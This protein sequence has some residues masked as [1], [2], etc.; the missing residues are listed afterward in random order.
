M[1]EVQ[2]N[3]LV[4]HILVQKLQDIEAFLASELDL[5][6]FD[7]DLNNLS[8]M[9]EAM[10]AKF[11]VYFCWCTIDQEP[12]KRPKFCQ[13]GWLTSLS[14]NTHA[15]SSTSKMDE[16]YAAENKKKTATDQIC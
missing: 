10:L 1:I 14:T 6:S 15:G 11:K 2:T 16:C 7:I 5:T 4:G 13:V 12:E 3:N 9:W 8:R